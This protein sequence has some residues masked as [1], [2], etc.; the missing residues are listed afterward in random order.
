LI[1]SLD[2]VEALW[3]MFDGKVE[4]TEGMKKIMLS[5]GATGAKAE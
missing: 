1:E 4:A 2:G 5:N 3:V